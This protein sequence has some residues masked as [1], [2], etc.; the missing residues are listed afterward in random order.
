MGVES[1]PLVSVN[2]SG[3]RNGDGGS[4]AMTR[5]DYLSQFALVV[6]CLVR[7]QGIWG[8]SS[9]VAGK[10]R[11]FPA[12]LLTGLYCIEGRPTSLKNTASTGLANATAVY[13]VLH[14]AGL[15]R[16]TL[17]NAP[18]RERGRQSPRGRVGLRMA[19]RQHQC[20]PL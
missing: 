2:P 14:T 19:C 4:S 7:E 18:A 6:I 5:S 10:Q 12:R 13:Y 15:N 20:K 17:A 1:G 3:R 16:S 11:C 8:V 9:R